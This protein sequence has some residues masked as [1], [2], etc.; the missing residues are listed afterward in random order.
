MLSTFRDKKR[1]KLF[2]S[3]VDEQ[4]MATIMF[5]RDDITIASQGIFNLL[6]KKLLDLDRT[7]RCIGDKY[8]HKIR[9]STTTEDVDL[10]SKVM[11]GTIHFKTPPSPFIN[12]GYY[13]MPFSIH[14]VD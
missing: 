10:K 13:Q 8:Y 7:G 4:F 3:K 5:N 11:N 1:V 14:R 12:N 6:N 2:V 9:N